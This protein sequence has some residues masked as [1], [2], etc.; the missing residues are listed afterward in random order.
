MSHG[1]ESKD[2]IKRRNARPDRRKKQ[3]SMGALW[4]K[5]HPKE[6]AQ[7]VKA[8]RSKNPHAKM[9]DDQRNPIELTLENVIVS[10]D[11]HVPFT[12]ESLIK[13]LFKTEKANGT[14][15]IIIAGDLFD[16]DNYSRFVHMTNAE[17]FQGELEEVRKELKRLLAHFNHIY[18]CRGNHEKRFCDMNAGKVGMKELVRLAMPSNISEDDFNKRVMVTTDDHIHLIHNNE[19]WLVCHPKNFRVVSL[20]VAKDLASKHL[21]NVATAHGHAFA[22]GRDRSGKF[23]VIELGGLFDRDSLDYTHETTCH[24]MMQGGYYLFNKGKIIPFEGGRT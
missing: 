21:C 8:Y 13:E 22:Q 5:K 3:S 20:S 18:I 10:S 17:T 24:P 4:K 11:W 6:N 16:C 12:D 2:S 23:K 1:I 15:D 7:N 9:I 14:K 19:K